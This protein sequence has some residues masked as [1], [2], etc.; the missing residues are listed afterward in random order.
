MRV[1]VCV[2]AGGK[3]SGWLGTRVFVNGRPAYNK[4]IS[5]H[6]NAYEQR[7]SKQ[8]TRPTDRPATLSTSTSELY[9]FISEV[10]K[11]VSSRER[12]LGAGRA[13]VLKRGKNCQATQ[14]KFNTFKRHS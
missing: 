6:G 11:K 10:V 2:W 8:A 7:T 5:S 13:P 14:G 4:Q 12:A 9:N 1:C 3:G